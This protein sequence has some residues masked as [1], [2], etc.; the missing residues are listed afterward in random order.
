MRVQDA[1]PVCSAD[2]VRNG[3]ACRAAHLRPVAD[4]MNWINGH[5]QHLIPATRTTGKTAIPIGV[6]KTHRLQLMSR[7]QATHR[8]W[9]F[10]ARAGLLTFTDPSGGSS[11][12]GYI[13]AP[14]TLRHVETV[15]A[16]ADG[17]VAVSWTIANS[18][19]STAVGALDSIACFELQR[20]DLAL[21]AT[22]DAV[23]GDTIVT[24][25]G[26]VP[27]PIL[28]TDAYTSIGA[29]S[30]GLANA[31]KYD[32]R[33]L[34]EWSAPSGDG[35]STASGSFVPLFEEG[36]V[37]LASKMYRVSVTGE[38]TAQF[39]VRTGTATTGEVRVTMTSGATVTGTIATATGGA[40]LA[41]SFDVDCEDLAATDGR[42][43]TRDDVCTIEVR[44]TAGAGG[45][46]IET[47]S[48]YEV[49]S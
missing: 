31:R 3:H 4:A 33:T 14:V 36:P 28:D 19:S 6:T 39:Y 46:D 18:A 8:V 12:W 48:I 5:G 27:A 26:G 11:S 13:G 37:L 25:S 29:L 9:V 1:F 10:S 22:D 21:N 7:A 41:V 45:V 44:R 24:L 35:F 34:F 38:V 47:I 30:R 32:R 20:R 2:G 16:P 23:D 49:R 15:T 42:R 43:A 40:W 17:P